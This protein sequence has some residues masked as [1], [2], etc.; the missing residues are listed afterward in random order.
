[1]N[2]KFT[3]VDMARGD[4]YSAIVVARGLRWYDKLLRKLHLSKATWRVKII[5]QELLETTPTNEKETS[6]DH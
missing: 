3:G 1:M 5:R 4:D 6:N 2:K